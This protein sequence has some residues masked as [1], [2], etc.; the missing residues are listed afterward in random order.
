M[1]SPSEGCGSLWSLRFLAIKPLVISFKVCDSPFSSNP[2]DKGHIIVSEG[3][4]VVLNPGKIRESKAQDIIFLIRTKKSSA[5]V[6]QEGCLKALKY[7]E[8]NG[9][10]SLAVP[11]V[12]SSKAKEH[13]TKALLAALKQFTP[14]HKMEIV[15]VVPPNDETTLGILR[16]TLPFEN[17]TH[18]VEE[19]YD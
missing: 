5:Q 3:D 10:N 4:I 19:E 1:I 17:V 2:G 14:Q 16:K 15:L 6:T 12:L 7:A 11:A 13:M 9:C 18:P 8:E